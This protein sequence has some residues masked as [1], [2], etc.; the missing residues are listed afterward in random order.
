MTSL[1]ARL[2]HRAGFWSGAADRLVL[3]Y[4]DRFLRRRVLRSEGGLDILVDLPR[5]TDLAEGDALETLDGQLVEI[6]AA[7]ETLLEIR[8]DLPRLA[9]HI[10]NRHTPAQI[11][12]DRVLI[13]EDAVM[14][15]MLV[16]L[17]AELSAVSE[18]FLPEGGAYGMGR[19]HGHDHGFGYG[20]GHG[21]GHGHGHD[22]GRDHRH[23]HD[24]GTAHAQPHD[25][26]Q[27]HGFS[28]GHPDV[29][30]HAHG[31]PPVHRADD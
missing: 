21:H 18:P 17:G 11:A 26:G 4:E 30:G 7:P 3:C 10:G 19:T 12:A 13:R 8:G 20:S 27:S 25:H 1:P 22:H 9:W 14:R 24:H 5:T 16:R 29:H 6:V 2:H 23:G 31:S 15:D 28:H